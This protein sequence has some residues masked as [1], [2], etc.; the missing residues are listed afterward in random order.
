[1]T[2]CRFAIEPDYHR[3]VLVWT[4]TIG[5]VPHFVNGRSML[6]LKWCNYLIMNRL[7]EFWTFYCTFAVQNFEYDIYMV[8]NLNLKQ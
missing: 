1:M 7:F 8:F 5:P 6:M 4:G 3:E 2:F